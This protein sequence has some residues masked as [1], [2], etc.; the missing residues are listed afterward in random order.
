MA[1]KKGLRG[2]AALTRVQFL[3]PECRL[4][5]T[6]LVSGGGISDKE[7][8]SRVVD[9]NLFRY[10]T[11]NSVGRVARSL[12][13][14][15][16]SLERPE[17]M[18]LLAQGE[19]TPEQA[20]QVNLYAM[21]RQHALME[22]FLSEEVG[23]RFCTLDYNLTYADMTSFFTR[24]AAESEV[25]ASWSDAT[26]ERL[27]GVLRGSLAR[28]GLLSDLSGETL[29]PVFLDPELRDGML[30]NGDAHLLAAFNC[31]DAVMA[32]APAFTG[33]ESLTTAEVARS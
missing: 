17:L 10:P 24:L 26:V 9:E 7:I 3:L 33:N 23:P 5:S 19:G 27:K 8:V 29:T 31:M 25:A 22:R 4:I 32:G 15:V 12:I 1:G 30:A 6:L 16:R 2:S 11:T 18:R 21:A 20:A 14:R 28:T 13:R